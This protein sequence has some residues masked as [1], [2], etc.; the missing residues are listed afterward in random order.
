MNGDV[1]WFSPDPKYWGR[2][3]DDV[4]V[5]TSNNDP[6]WPTLTNQEKWSYYC[7]EKK[8]NCICFCWIKWPLIGN[9]F[10]SEM[11]VIRRP[12][13]ALSM[14]KDDTPFLNTKTACVRSASGWLTTKQTNKQ[15][16]QTKKYFLNPPSVNLN[17]KD[18]LFLSDGECVN[19]MYFFLNTF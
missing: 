16:K 5:S 8:D 4:V 2:Q 17:P 11:V 13:N 9:L 1:K 19:S 7:Y 12:H 3:T 15:N 6:I 14:Y 18:Q 10:D